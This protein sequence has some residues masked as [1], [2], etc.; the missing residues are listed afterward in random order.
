MIEEDLDLVLQTV[1]R[2]TPSQEET[3]S[4]TTTEKEGLPAVTETAT[5][6]E[7]SRKVG[8]GEEIQDIQT[9]EGTSI[10]VE[11][12]EGTAD[13]RKAIVIVAMTGIEEIAIGSGV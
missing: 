5:I 11:I 8:V 7:M 10:L 1:M 6:Q 3:V 4:P 9:L 13:V 2:D 12:L